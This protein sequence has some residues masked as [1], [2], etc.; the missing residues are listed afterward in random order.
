MYICVCTCVYMFVFMCIYTHMYTYIHTMHI[1]YG[2]MVLHITTAKRYP[3]QSRRPPMPGY[4]FGAS[5]L[6]CPRPPRLS[7][8]FVQTNINKFM[9]IYICV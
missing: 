8:K 4:C 2:Y 9:C 6:S 1:H 7:C 5:A 3:D